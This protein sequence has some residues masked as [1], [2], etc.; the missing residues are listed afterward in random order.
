M[1]ESAA[2]FSSSFEDQPHK[3]YDQGSGMCS[4]HCSCELKVFVYTTQSGAILEFQRRRGDTVAFSKVFS[5]VRLQLEAD[6]QCSK[7]TPCV[8]DASRNTCHMHTFQD[9][10]NDGVEGLAPLLAMAHD[11]SDSEMQ[12][13]VAFVLQSAIEDNLCLAEQLCSQE[14]RRALENLLNAE[15]FRV[16]YPIARLLSFISSCPGVMQ[17]FWDREHPQ[18]IR[19]VLAKLQ[20]RSTIR[21]VKEEL[22]LSLCCFVQH[23]VMDSDTTDSARALEKLIKSAPVADTTKVW[24]PVQFEK[25]LA[26]LVSLLSGSEAISSPCRLSAACPFVQ[27]TPV[28]VY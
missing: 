11:S 19:L 20:D 4:P 23:S 7:E 10:S 1:L 27:R 26:K 18:L 28:H 2:E 21:M 3:V 6:A 15:C 25:A 9:D 13:E 14:G 5:A 17:L 24:N 16:V 22:A 12:A 8:V